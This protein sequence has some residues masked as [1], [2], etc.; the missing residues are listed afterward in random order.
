MRIGNVICPAL[1]SLPADLTP[2]S[3]EDRECRV[4]QKR[5]KN[6]KWK[7]MG[8]IL[9]PSLSFFFVQETLSG[10]LSDQQSECKYY[11]RFI[12]KSLILCLFM[13]EM[14]S[15]QAIQDLKFSI[16]WLAHQWIICSEWVPSEW[17]SKLLI[18]T[19]QSYVFKI[20]KSIKIF[21]ALIRCF[22][23]KYQSII[24]NNA[25]SSETV[26]FLVSSHI[27][28]H[29][30]ICLGLFFTVFICKQWFICAYFSPD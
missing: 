27:K 28:I 4:F 25:S 1:F 5:M 13:F 26:H 11:L 29:Q 23:P 22:W 20:N 3:R 17:E 8:F 10:L 14:Y 9:V 12:K 21:L 19:L 7:K 24:H 16:T 6:H 15:L 2:G 18:R 30:H